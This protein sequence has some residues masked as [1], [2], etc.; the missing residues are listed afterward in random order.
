MARKQQDKLVYQRKPRKCPECGA[1]QIAEYLFGM[2]DYPGIEQ[3]LAEGKIA[4]GGCDISRMWEGELERAW[5]CNQCGVDLFRKDQAQN[6]CGTRYTG[7]TVEG[8]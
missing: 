6:R 8:G 7:R 2:V 1:K 3:D 4:I 5:R